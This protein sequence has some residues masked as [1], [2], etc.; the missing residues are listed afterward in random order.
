[1]FLSYVKQLLS[2]EKSNL[3]DLNNFLLLLLLLT[4]FSWA[5]V[6]DRVLTSV[7]SEQASQAEKGKFV[8][9][10]VSLFINS[11]EK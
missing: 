1:M 5:L 4:V 8:K 3:F 9:V 11:M 10:V 7:Q 2:I 6:S